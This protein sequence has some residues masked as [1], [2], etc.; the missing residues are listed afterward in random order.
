MRRL[1][2][3]LCGFLLLSSASASAQ[4]PPPRIGPFVLDVHATVPR[5]PSDNAQLAASRGLSPAQLPGTGLGIQIGAHVYVLRLKAITFGLGA[6]VATGRATK[7]PDPSSGLAPT[8]ERFSTFAPELS[9]NFGNGH[10]WSY[11]SGGVGAANW[12]IVPEGHEK[13]PADLERLKTFNYGGGARWF[14]RPH[15]AFSLDVRIYVISPGTPYFQGALGGPHTN[16]LIIGAGISV[17]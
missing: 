10:G 9:F 4:E 3:A 7:T 16:L 11:L 8:E 2:A 5:F 12:S 6:E 13:G 17:K 15:L 1:F 14:V